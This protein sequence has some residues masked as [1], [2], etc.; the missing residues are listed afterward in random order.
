MAAVNKLILINRSQENNFLQDLGE[1]KE[2]QAQKVKGGGQEL[3]QTLL[4]ILTLD[5]TTTTAIICNYSTV[6]S[7]LF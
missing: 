6:L 4:V 3:F 1:P 5:S 7:D 2:N